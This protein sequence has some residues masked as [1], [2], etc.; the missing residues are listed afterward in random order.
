MLLFA[1]PA[2]AVELI[3][4][5]GDF[6]DPN[7]TGVNQ[8]VT[9]TDWKTTN[10]T[11][12]TNM[13]DKGS[14]AKIPG[15]SN[16]NQVIRLKANTNGGMIRR[17]GVGISWD[18]SHVYQLTFNAC[19]VPWQ[20]G[21]ATQNEL[22]VRLKDKDAGW[23]VLWTSGAID[24]DG[25]HDNIQTGDWEP[26][27][28]FSY[29]IN[30]ADFTTGTPGGDL[31]LEFDSNVN[32]AFLD[33]VSMTVD[34]PLIVISGQ[35]QSQVSYNGDPCDVVFSVDANS[36]ETI[37]YTWFKS[38]DNITDDSNDTQVGTN[39]NTLTI[40]S[41]TETDESYYY[42]KLV[43]NSDTKYT[44]VVTLG[45][46]RRM[47]RWTLDSSDYSG[48]QYIDVASATDS[49]DHNATVDGTP[50]FVTAI[51]DDGVHVNDGNGTANAGTWDPME[52]TNQMT[53]AFW[54]N[55]DE[56]D[57][58]W[59]V[60]ISKK[61][62]SGDPNLLWRMSIRPADSML[63]FGRDSGP[64][65]WLDMPSNGWVFIA[66]THNGSSGFSTLYMK[67]DDGTPDFI[68]DSGNLTLGNKKNAGFYIGR[69]L[70]SS[71][72]EG[73]LD[74]IMVYNH[75]LTESELGAIYSA[76]SGNPLC[77][78]PYSDTYDYN[79]DCII[80]FLDFADLASRWYDDGFYPSP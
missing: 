80:N 30:A 77:L 23:A 29:D 14:N 79:N 16:D 21:E 17:V 46:E 47:A 35:P 52:F 64:R 51:V 9:A 27:Q 76:G 61:D 5:N 26:N 40:T 60:L 13:D 55:W 18:A 11:D 42:C 63:N 66:V 41:Q 19:E 44:N 72:F 12:K 50:N 58:D 7:I 38:V 6:Q 20:S 57:G 15:D 62:G 48:G 39:S 3:S 22:E 78:N 10:S 71:A 31:V 68:K 24:L 32:I 69:A 54:A 43:T 28:T 4:T 33:N 73:V 8:W 2:L 56:N 25:T 59:E 75:V 65:L 45:M 49:V 34:L 67:K 37:T 36:P 74:D 1:G 70:G 53:I